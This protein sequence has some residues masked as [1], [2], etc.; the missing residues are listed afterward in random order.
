MSEQPF[1]AALFDND[2]NFIKKASQDKYTKFERLLIA[3]ISDAM[4]N[5]GIDAKGK[6]TVLII[7]ST[8]GNISLLET[9]TYNRDLQTRISLNTSA[10]MIAE[11]FHFT[12]Q[13]IVVSTAFS[14]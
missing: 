14:Y 12:N 3:S 8:K 11:Y 4:V 1:Y 2:K 7:S 5:S 9:E 13:P 6:K 10:K